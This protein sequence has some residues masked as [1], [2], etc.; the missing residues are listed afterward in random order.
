MR[1]RV[2]KASHCFSQSAK[3]TQG[4]AAAGHYMTSCSFSSELSYSNMNGSNGN[5][6]KAFWRAWNCDLSGIFSLQESDGCQEKCPLL[7]E[8]DGRSVSST[9]PALPPA[10][11]EALSPWQMKT[12]A[13]DLGTSILNVKEREGGVHLGSQTWRRRNRSWW[14]V[15]TNVPDGCSSSDI[16]VGYMFIRKLQR[17]S[18]PRWFLSEFLPPERQWVWYNLGERGAPTAASD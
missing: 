12:R 10:A 11:P 14:R 1:Y 6:G 15:V 4:D 13:Q 18:E 16:K 8:A 17:I 3:G 5:R 2:L 9:S 7:W